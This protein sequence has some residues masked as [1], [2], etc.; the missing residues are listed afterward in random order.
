MEWKP[1]PYRY[2]AGFRFPF[3]ENPFSLSLHPP[4][5]AQSNSQWIPADR[6][7]LSSD[8]EGQR[9]EASSAN[10]S[11]GSTLQV[12]EYQIMQAPQPTDSTWKEKKQKPPF[13]SQGF[14]G[15]K[16][17]SPLWQT[18]ALTR[19]RGQAVNSPGCPQGMAYFKPACKHLP[20][21][22][23]YFHGRII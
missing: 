15:I 11:N 19:H 9:K 3:V 1:F 8:N 23:L 20:V 7:A 12:A 10:W 22:V 21:Y 16:H 5:H 14:A 13:V 4:Q 18:Q 2:A 17:S 6:N